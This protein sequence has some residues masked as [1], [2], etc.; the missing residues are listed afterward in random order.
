MGRKIPVTIQLIPAQVQLSPFAKG[1]TLLRRRVLNSYKFRLISECGDAQL[2][3]DMSEETE[4][5]KDEWE[6]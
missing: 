2:T 1:G 5:D 4:W 6:W 3:G